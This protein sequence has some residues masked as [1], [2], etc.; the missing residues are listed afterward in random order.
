MFLNFEHL[1][2]HKKAKTNVDRDQTEFMLNNFV[3]LSLCY[4]H[5]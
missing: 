2:P 3:Y 1:L 5:I 4:S